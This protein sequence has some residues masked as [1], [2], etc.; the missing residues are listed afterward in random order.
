M[1]KPILSLLWSIVF[2]VA[3]NN[4]SKEEDNSASS[5]RPVKY[6][7]VGNSQQVGQLT[8]T[9]LAKAQQ[10]ARLSFKVGGTV[11]QIPIKV[12]DRVRKGQLLALL[13]ATDYQVSYNQS[14]A[15]V[16]SAKSQIESAQAQLENARANFLNAQSNYNRFE[17]LYETNS[18]SLSDFEQAKS[19]YLSAE[20][21]LKAA[22]TQV[23]AAIAGEK[24]SESMAR[25]ASNQINYT[26]IEAP[27]AGIISSINIEPNE[28]VGQ[29]NPIIELNSIGN[30]DVEIGVSENAIATITNDQQVEVRFNSI[31]EKTFSGT[32]HEIGF[33]SAGTTFPVTIRLAESEN[34]IRPGMPASATFSFNDQDKLQLIVPPGAVAKDVS[35][36]FVYLIQE[37]SQNQFVCKKQ[38]VTI[39]RLR[40]AGFEI[41]DGL[42]PGNKIASAGLDLLY[43]G[44]RVK[45][46]RN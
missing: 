12:G 22:E 9:G 35:G 15:N 43:D 23:Q 44:M 37:E 38:N 28:I 3:C 46:Y 6:L 25:S 24:S 34:R 26:R 10:V 18:I 45:L 31:P 14:L 4:G 29:G 7:T 8:Y 36:H 42:S 11:S 32:V 5:I 39:G 27:F 13:D 21:S 17:K 33:S 16:Q 1:N 30:P 2:L 20:A 19:N 40:D 41:L